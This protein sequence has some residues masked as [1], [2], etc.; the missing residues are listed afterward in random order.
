MLALALVAP[1]TAT[2]HHHP[3]C[4]VTTR[5]AVDFYR[6]STWRRQDDRLARRTHSNY[7]ERRTRSCAYTRWLARRWYLRARAERTLHK[8]WFSAMYAKWRCIHRGEGA[9]DEDNGNGYYG[10]LQMDLSFQR[11]YGG[12]FYRRFGTA[13]KWPVRAQLIAAERAYQSG[14]GFYPWPQTARACGLL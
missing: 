12:E 14:R 6:S 3:N 10:G 11:S 7:S 2:N 9:W 5:H 4:L 8:S 13:D 1:A